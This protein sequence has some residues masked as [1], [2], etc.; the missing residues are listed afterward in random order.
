MQHI[1]SETPQ[2]AISPAAGLCISVPSVLSQH[3]VFLNGTRKGTIV[4]KFKKKESI[5][6]GDREQRHFLFC[7]CKLCSLMRLQASTSSCHQ[8]TCNRD[9]C[10]SP[11]ILGALPYLEWGHCTRR[12]HTYIFIHHIPYN[13]IIHEDQ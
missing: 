10:S 3:C 9:M 11:S 6:A 12:C 4:A 5:K 8:T 2:L 7:W 13:T 1:K